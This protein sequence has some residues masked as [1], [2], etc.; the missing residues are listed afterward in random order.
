MREPDT[1]EEL[2]AKWEAETKVT[3]P[4][5]E[6][7]RMAYEFANEYWDDPEVEKTTNDL[8]IV[9]GV[10]GYLAGFKAA[11]EQAE[12]ISRWV[13]TGDHEE[14]QLVDLSDLKRLIG[15]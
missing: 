8:C 4:Q 14:Q 10:S 15:E 7:E 9:C 2:R 5:S 13:Q 1:C 12:K 11:I 6:A 3:K